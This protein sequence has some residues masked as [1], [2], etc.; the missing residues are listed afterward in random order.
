MKVKL[1]LA[2]LMAASFLTA[3]ADKPEWAG[4]GQ[5]TAEQKAAHRASMKAKGGDEI[6]EYTR[7]AKEHKDKEH[8][9]ASG[10]VESGRAVIAA[11]EAESNAVVS[12]ATQRVERELGTLESEVNTQRVEKFDL[13]QKELD[14]GS[15]K[16]KVASQEHSRHWWSFWE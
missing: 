8:R 6:V 13:D 1:A 3:Y 16:V 9:Q 2:A 11:I 5:P 7:D 14:K 12:E 15:E 4:Q 10:D